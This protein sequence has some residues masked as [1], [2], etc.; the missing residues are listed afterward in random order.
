MAGGPYRSI[1]L[2]LEPTDRG[3]TDGTSEGHVTPV[4]DDEAPHWGHLFSCTPNIELLRPPEVLGVTSHHTGPGK[5]SVIMAG[6]TSAPAN[7]GK[8]AEEENLVENVEDLVKH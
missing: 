4:I 5:Y 6:E 7:D 8:K 1:A 3:D 2:N